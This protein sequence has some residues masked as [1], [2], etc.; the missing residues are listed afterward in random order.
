M[1]QEEFINENSRVSEYS[2][3][4]EKEKKYTN[5]RNLI[6]NGI[7]NITTAYQRQVGFSDNRDLENKIVEAICNIYDEEIKTINKMME[8][9]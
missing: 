3:L 4:Q 7:L 8:L 1:T 5:A 9:L 2:R 6:E